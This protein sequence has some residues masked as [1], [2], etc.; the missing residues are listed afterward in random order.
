MKLKTV[1]CIIVTDNLIVS[2]LKIQFYSAQ[3]LTTLHSQEGIPTAYIAQIYV[4]NLYGMYN[5]KNH[6]AASDFDFTT[7][8][9]S[10]K[11]LILKLS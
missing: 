2:S 8:N 4:P 10:T 6:N 7:L 9:H 3:P 1:I 5:V 11:R